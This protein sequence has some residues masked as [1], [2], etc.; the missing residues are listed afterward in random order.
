MRKLAKPDR[1]AL[2]IRIVTFLPMREEKG[3]AIR[4][5]VCRNRSLPKQPQTPNFDL[6]RRSVR[7]VVQSRVEMLL[8]VR[9]VDAVAAVRLRERL[10][11]ERRKQFVNLLVVPVA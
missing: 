11:E 9:R 6:T 8:L 4:P 3:N 7:Y 1:I 10:A 2:P 5:Q